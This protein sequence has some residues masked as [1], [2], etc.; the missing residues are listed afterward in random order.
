MKKI[1]LTIVAFSFIAIISRAQE[2]DLDLRNNMMFGIKLGLNLSNVYDTKG[3]AFTTDPKLGLAFGGFISIPITKYFGIQPELL[4]SQKGYQ[5]TG[6][7][8]GGTY[9]L[10]HTSDFIDIPILIALK[11]SSQITVLVGPQYSFLFRQTD[12]F[13]NS[14][15]SAVQEQQFTN[16]NLRVNTFCFIG[17]L[18][19]NLNHLVIGGRIGWDVLDNNGDGTSTTPR[20]KNVWY[21]ATIG[22]RFF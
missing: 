9:H 3:D 1:F 13:T 18:D 20:Y 11:P 15:I 21:Q 12:V 17:G 22:Y 14:N 5:T 8:L 6:N 4:I 16:S 10:T 19:V 2:N 7:F